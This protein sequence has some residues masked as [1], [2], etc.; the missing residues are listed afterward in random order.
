MKRNGGQKPMK[1]YVFRNVSFD[2]EDTICIL[3]HSRDEAYKIAEEE[4]S[5]HIYLIK[6]VEKPGVVCC[7]EGQLWKMRT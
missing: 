7:V 5:R 3:A 2:R 4:C 6:T 1:A